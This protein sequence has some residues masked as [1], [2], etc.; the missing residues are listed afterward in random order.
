MD[1]AAIRGGC[2]GVGPLSG[3]VRPSTRSGFGRGRQRSRVV[4]LDPTVVAG[5]DGFEGGGGSATGGDD[6]GDLGC[7][8]RCSSDRNV[9]G[10]VVAVWRSCGKS[11]GTIGEHFR[12]FR[13]HRRRRH[14][15]RWWFQLRERKRD[16]CE[17]EKRSTGERGERDSR[18]RERYL[19][20]NE[21][22]V[23]IQIFVEFRYL[24]N[25]DIL[26]KLGYFVEI[27]LDRYE[28]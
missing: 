25:L 15:G 24:L 14:G 2:D 1:G 16:I 4:C 27:H 19:Y 9:C 5:F 26:S 21:I 10:C 7:F 18:E 13:R 20:E 28:I 23:E 12:F 11:L 17:R 6:G 22:F 8:R 3:V